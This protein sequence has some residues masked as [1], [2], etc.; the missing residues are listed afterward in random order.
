MIAEIITLAEVQAKFAS[1]TGCSFVSLDLCTIPKLTGG[2]ANP[3]QG[4][5]RKYSSFQAF[6]GSGVS[7]ENMVNK[8]AVSEFKSIIGEK[9]VEVRPFQAESMWKGKGERVAGAVIRHNET[10]VKYIYFY[11]PSNSVPSVRYEF[12]GKEIAKS[13]IQGLADHDDSKVVVVDGLVVSVELVT[14][15]AKMES[16]R[17]FRMDGKAFVVAE[18]I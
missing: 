7:Y 9:P 13:E 17:G 10:D 2:K 1:I 5:I 18:N 8:R 15:T 3:H 12:E 11:I 16:I 6:C 14:R 4:N